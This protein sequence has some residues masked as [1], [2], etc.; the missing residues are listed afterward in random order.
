MEALNIT[1][2]NANEKERKERGREGLTNFQKPKSV[3]LG[4]KEEGKGME[5]TGRLFLVDETIE[6]LP[7]QVVRNFS[8]K[9]DPSGFCICRGD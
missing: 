4:E 6:G 7:Y 1:L 9:K 3:F 5:D 8:Y 2:R